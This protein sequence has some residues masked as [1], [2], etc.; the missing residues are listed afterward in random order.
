MRCNN[1]ALERTND[2][3]K[4]LPFYENQSKLF[5]DF[6]LIGTEDFPFPVLISSPD[7]NPTEPRDGVFLTCKNTARIDEE[8]EV[9]RS[10][11]EKACGL[12]EHLL[13]YVAK[14]KWDGIYNI[15]KVNAYSVDQH[16]IICHFQK[17]K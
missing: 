17:N 10:I 9:N 3:M 8:I 13:E 14:K 4:I 1:I 15:S 12:Y 5:C 6:P 7:F 11:I 2:N 16:I